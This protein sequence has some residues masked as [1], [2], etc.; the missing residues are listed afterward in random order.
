ML[1]DVR[2]D[3]LLV[4]VGTGGG[5]TFGR[6]TLCDWDMSVPPPVIVPLPGPDDWEVLDNRC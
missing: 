5:D 3:I 2:F 6:L 1:E 4:V